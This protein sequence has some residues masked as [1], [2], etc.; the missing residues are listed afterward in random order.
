MVFRAKAQL[1]QGMTSRAVSAGPRFGWIT[2]DTVYGNDRRLR[3]WLEEQSRP[4]VLAVKNNEP[5]WADTK[6]GSAQVAAREL[7]SQIPADRWQRLSVGDGSK[8]PRL[9]D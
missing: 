3:R 1:A 9:Y 2:A 5:L 4:H 6:G 7:A 8:G